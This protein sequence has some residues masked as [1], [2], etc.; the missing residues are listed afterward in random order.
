MTHK[1]PELRASAVVP[2]AAQKPVRPTKPAALA[3]KKPPKLALEGNKWLVV[4][5]IPL[6][7]QP[8]STAAD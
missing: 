8:S 1:N 3:G 6:L 7:L 2:A 5:P 4:R